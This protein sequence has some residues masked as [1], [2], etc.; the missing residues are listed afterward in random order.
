MHPVGICIG[1]IGSSHQ[2]R[3][4]T[5]E[6]EK[7]TGVS[8][9]QC[10]SQKGITLIMKEYK[11]IPL[12]VSLASGNIKDDYKD[13]IKKHAEDGW[14]LVQIFTAWNFTIAEIILERDK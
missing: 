13:I 12:R 9:Q 3:R 11:F 4:N 1:Y 14:R 5:I 10:S 6:T 7:N 8:Q 2:L